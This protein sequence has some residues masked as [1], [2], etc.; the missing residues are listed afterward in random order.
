MAYDKSFYPVL[1]EMLDDDDD[2][3]V[4]EVKMLS[5]LTAQE[6]QERRERLNHE[7][8]LT[9]K[10]SDPSLR[11]SISLQ[12]S[13]SLPD[14]GGGVRVDSAAGKV[15]GSPAKTAIYSQIA[16]PRPHSGRSQ[17]GETGATS[18][19]RPGAGAGVPSGS[20]VPPPLPAVPPNARSRMQAELIRIP[21]PPQNVQRNR[22]EIASKPRD[23]S[24]NRSQSLSPPFS[25][26]NLT[27]YSIPDDIPGQHMAP[28]SSHDKPLI[29]LSPPTKPERVDDFDLK[30]LDP[31]RPPSSGLWNSSLAKTISDPVP[32]NLY[33]PSADPK[34]RNSP[35]P[36]PVDKPHLP[37]S[38]YGSDTS[39][40]YPFVPW[41]TNDLTSPSSLGF[42]ITWVHDSGGNIPAGCAA[43]METAGR[44]TR[45]GSVASA[46][47]SMS[48]D[49]MDF[50]TDDG[51]Y[52]LDPVYMDLADFDPLYTVD[53]KAWNFEQRFDSDELFDKPG[54]TLPR[55]AAHSDRWPTAPQ[56]PAAPLPDVVAQSSISRLA[57]VAELQDP[58]SVQDLMASLEKKRRK[59]A[60]EQETQD[61]SVV[62]RQR[63][64]P[65]NNALSVAA[66]APK[67][68]VR[69]LLLL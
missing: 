68:E 28:D 26:T 69:L 27:S 3:I 33:R 16:R 20:V 44:S 65:A 60:R 36:S 2:D 5:L 10:P 53:S 8:N 42:P 59:H 61:L 54:T 66:A 57:S 63:P 30:L 67:R 7:L 6:D 64:Q 49:L 47:S 31:L 48:S 56:R 35:V 18:I 12:E 9:R 22:K 14:L 41:V 25:R 38:T 17:V 46:G 11:S 23:S 32:Q 4:R 13:S 45:P 29:C 52:Q 62:N 55:S 19:P 39:G 24:A 21:S 37:S 50:S 58:F 51:S 15:E 34:Y 43:A 1:P 40:G